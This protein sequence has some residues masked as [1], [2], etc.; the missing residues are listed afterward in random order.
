MIL[1]FPGKHIP[2]TS[3]VF[4]Q[5]PLAIPCVLLLLCIYLTVAPFI[6]NPKIEFLYALA[7]LGIGAVLYFPFVFFKL[8]VPGFGKV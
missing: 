3:F 6:R 7:F 4:F 2:S 8:Q 1:E 5:V